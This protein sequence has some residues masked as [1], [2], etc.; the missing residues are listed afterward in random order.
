[1]PTINFNANHSWNIGL[2]QNITTGLFE[3]MTTQFSSGNLSLGVDI[4]RG[5]QNFIQLYRANLA[6]LAR[7][8][9]IEDIMDDTKLLVANAYLQIMFNKEI[10]NVQKTQLDIVKR[11]LERTP[12]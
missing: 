7:Q 9:Q 11:Q 4:Y 3:N 10:V 1:M 8:Y 6:L 5:K 12:I 2:N